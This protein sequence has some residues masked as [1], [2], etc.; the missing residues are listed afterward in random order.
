MSKETV[1]I[2]KEVLLKLAENN[3]IISDKL[4]KISNRLK[5]KNRRAF[6]N[7]FVGC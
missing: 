1:T 2:P 4:E 7:F 5:L 6:F 3:K